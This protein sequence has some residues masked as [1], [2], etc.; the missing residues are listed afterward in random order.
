MDQ[1]ATDITENFLEQSGQHNNLT[2][3]DIVVDAIDNAPIG[4]D[5]EFVINP[6]QIL[7]LDQA[8]LQSI[9]RC[10]EYLVF[11]TIRIN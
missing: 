11:F 4:N 9:D 5:R 3:E 2:E 7:G 8:V 1:S 6:G 10:R